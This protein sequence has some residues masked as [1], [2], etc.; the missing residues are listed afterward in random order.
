MEHFN[1]PRDRPLRFAGSWSVRLKSAGYHDS[2]IHP[3]GWIS[4]ALYL[5]LPH[6]T[7]DESPEAGY[8]KLG[9][10]PTELGVEL[11]ATRLIEPAVGRLVLFPSWLW[12]GTLPFDEGERLTVAFDVKRPIRHTQP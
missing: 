2:H 3:Q 8:L 1:L 5:A 9:E 11:N 12:H 6:H 10:P 4:S 7:A